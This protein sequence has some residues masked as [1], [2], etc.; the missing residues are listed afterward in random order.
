MAGHQLG[1][2]VVTRCHAALLDQPRQIHAQL[3]PGLVRDPVPLGGVVARNRVQAGGNGVGPRVDARLVLP[4]HPEQ[5][6]GASTRMAWTGHAATARA[7]LW[8]CSSSA[9]GL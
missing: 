2:H 9:R 8:R 1:E 6:S 7:T 4:Q 3:H 5:P